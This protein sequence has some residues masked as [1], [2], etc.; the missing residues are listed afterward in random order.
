M[1]SPKLFFLKK[2]DKFYN[3]KQQLFFSSI[4][5]GSYEKT[6]PAVESLIANFDKFK[7]C[8]VH[9]I[10]EDALFEEYCGVTT[11]TVL[12]GAYFSEQLTELDDCLP[13]ISQ[14]G[15]NMHKKINH[16]IDALHPLSAYKQG[17]LKVE[18]DNTDAAMGYLGEFIHKMAKIKMDDMQDFIIVLDGFIADRKSIVGIAKKVKR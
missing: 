8:E 6:R 14:V 17:F 16:A 15:K 3:A 2:G 4:T 10:T 7:G 9:V 13:T 1:S 18:E 5:N 11:R 12:A